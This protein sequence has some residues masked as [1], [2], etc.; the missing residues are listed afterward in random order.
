M[1]LFHRNNGKGLSGRG[2]TGRS[3]SAGL[4]L[5][6][7][8]AIIICFSASATAIGDDSVYVL[9]FRGSPGV[10][11]LPEG[12]EHVTYLGKQKNRFL[13]EDDPEAVAVTEAR[14][15]DRDRNEAGDNRVLR[16]QSVGSVSAL[17]VRPGVNLD[18]FPRLSWR[19]KVNRVVGMARENERDRNDSAARVR[20][21]FGGGGPELPSSGGELLNRLLEMRGIDRGASEPAGMKIDYIWG[22]HF[23]AGTVIDYPGGRNH[24]VVFLQSGQES[25]GQW[26]REE[27]DLLE[28]YREFFGGTPSGLAGILVFSDTDR[29]NEGVTA[30]FADLVLSGRRDDSSP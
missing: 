19:W 12:W 9:G 6:T 27:R 23:P 3:V 30:W 2:G 14:D 8:A 26:M 11:S 10:D 28:D 13:L 7:M 25:A 4:V 21:V 5:A 15:D 20:V 17:S 24:R 1:Y 18:G 22:S 16:V 29:T